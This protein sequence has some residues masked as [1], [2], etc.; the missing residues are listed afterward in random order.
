MKGIIAVGVFLVAF[1]VYGWGHNLYNVTQ[2][3]SLGDAGGKE[4]MQIIGI[5]AAPVGVIM[6][7]IY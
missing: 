3:E 7:Y 1:T 6:G 5:P 4:I 2:I